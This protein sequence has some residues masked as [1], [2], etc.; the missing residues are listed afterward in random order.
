MWVILFVTLPI[1]L[2]STG[3]QETYG[4]ILLGRRAKKRNLPLPPQG[5]QGLAAVKMLLT[6][7]LT[8]P[9]RMLCT[10]PIVAFLSLYVAFVFAVLFAF[11]AAFPLV[12]QGVYGFNAGEGGLAFLGIGLGV[13]ISVATAL[14]ANKLLYQKQHDLAIAEGRTA[15]D[16]EHRL[17]PAMWA[18]IGLP[19]GL[20]MFAFSSRKDVHW[21]VPVLA[22]VPFAW[23]NLCIFV[24]VSTKK[25]LVNPCLFANDVL[26][27]PPCYT[28]LTSMVHLQAH[29]PRPRMAY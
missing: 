27:F 13:L 11:F 14:L 23:A 20:F 21:I 5:A 18:S 10:E 12:F 4:K 16:P 8:R 3:M 1:Y 19:I 7:T 2:F 25:P 24:G 15:A 9:V 29:L 28:C 22:T 26:R 17:Y 6:I